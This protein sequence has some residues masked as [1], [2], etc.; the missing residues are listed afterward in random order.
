MKGRI[1]RA[2]VSTSAHHNA[3]TVGGV[4]LIPQLAPSAAAATEL[5]YHHLCLIPNPNAT[6]GIVIL[7]LYY[8]HFRQP[9]R[10]N[11]NPSIQ[12]SQPR[13]KL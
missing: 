4:D 6:H 8:H 5:L 2:L 1:S 13:K 9:Y 3:A 12:L 10:N 7:S 11:A